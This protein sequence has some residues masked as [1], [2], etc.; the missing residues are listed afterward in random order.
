MVP[1]A[2]GGSTLRLGGRRVAW[3]IPL[4][5]LLVIAGL[6]WN[7]DGSFRMISWI[8]VVPG[9][10]AAICGVW[11]TGG[12]AVVSVL[13]YLGMDSLWSERY[14]NGL[15]DFILV[16]L[17]SVIAVFACAVRRRDE[18]YLGHIQAVAETTRRTVLRPLPAHWAG[19][20]HAAVYLAADSEARVGGDFYDIQPSRFG[21]RVIVGDVQGKGLDAVTAASAILGSFREWGFHER[22]LGVAA[23]KLEVRMRRYQEYRMEMGQDEGDRFATAALVGFPPPGA[24]DGRAVELVDFGHEPPLAVG[25]RGV[26]ELETVP[27]L[28]LGM[29]ELLDEAPVVV[30]LDLADDETLLLVTDGVTE[31][32]D[33]SGEFF[34]LREHLAA[35]MARDPLLAAPALLVRLVRDATLRY[36]GGRL[37]DDTTVLAVRRSAPPLLSAPKRDP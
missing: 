22:D 5:L 6:D 34:P 4:A 29:S 27:V 32:R 23:A 28:P 37:T 17:G 19:L 25:P 24:A 18:R 2:R 9:T 36:T 20:D 30:T 1:L 16:A 7:T 8:I 31:A 33:R 26:R 3:L 15:P 13:A 10:A 21:T 35:A 12:F 14:R 11:T